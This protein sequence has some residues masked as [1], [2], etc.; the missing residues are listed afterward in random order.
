MKTKLLP[1]PETLQSQAIWIRNEKLEEVYWQ[2]NAVY[3]KMLHRE[4]KLPLCGAER[5]P[6]KCFC[7]SIHVVE[8]LQ[9][10]TGRIVPI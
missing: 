10:P 7:R 4:G 6:F 3:I 5:D 9:V 1:F 8:K 2:K